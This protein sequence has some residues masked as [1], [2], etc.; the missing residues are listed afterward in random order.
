MRLGVKSKTVNH[1]QAEAGQSIAKQ[2]HSGKKK[3]DYPSSQKI[4]IKE[5]PEQ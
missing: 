1:E 5:I 4:E 3:A 2:N